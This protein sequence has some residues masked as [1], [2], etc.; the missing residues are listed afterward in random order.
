MCIRDR[1]DLEGRLRRLPPRSAVFYVVVSE[2]GAGEHFQVMASL[3]RVAA[4]ANAP[5]YSW[6]DGAVDAGIVGGSRRDQ[7]AETKAIATLALRVLGGERAD[8]IP[9][10]SPNTDV[11]LVD[12]RQLRRWG[13]AESRLP[14]GTRVLFR[15]PT[16][17]DQYERYIVG[18][19]MLML[20]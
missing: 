8:D 17:W 20:A 1:R 18:A 3:A 19:L 2:D 11:D 13:L 6:A 14:T 16:V 5:T 7:L 9:V 10:S 4:A 12:W 15:E